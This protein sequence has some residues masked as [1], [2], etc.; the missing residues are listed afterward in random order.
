MPELACA[1]VK[2]KGGGGTAVGRGGGGGVVVARGAVA[3]PE[4]AV[5]CVRAM[6]F[7]SESR[8]SV[9]LPLDFDL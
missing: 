1:G 4:R 7:W 5:E 2:A 9:L 8:G 3:A 6:V